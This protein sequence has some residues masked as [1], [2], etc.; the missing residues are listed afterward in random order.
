MLPAVTAVCA[1]AVLAI[2]VDAI[3]GLLP[4]LGSIKLKKG[5]TW[6]TRR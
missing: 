1:T 6:S 5:K 2:L 4:Y 3:K